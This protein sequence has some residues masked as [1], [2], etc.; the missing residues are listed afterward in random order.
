MKKILLLSSILI[1]IVMPLKA[2]QNKYRN[3]E[4]TLISF[5]III[6]SDTKKCLDSF[7]NY[8]PAIKKSNADKIIAKIKEQAWGSIV[9]VLQREIGMIIL[10]VNT[11][12]D[13]ISY[14]SYGFPDVNVSKAQRKGYSKFYMKIEMQIGPEPAIQYPV[15]YKSKKD[16]TSQ[17]GKLKAGEI[18]PVVTITLTT[19]PDNGLVP[20][21]KFI[22]VAESTTVWSTTNETILDGLINTNVTTDLSNFMSLIN[23]AVNDL[24]INMLIE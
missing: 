3:K 23:E 1:I 21:D 18:K 9:D 4:I 5:N 6:H 17:S 13:K 15:S 20:L 2:L 12:G 22:G 19:Y 16:T 8:F 10:P 11:F 24:S 14:D 7:E